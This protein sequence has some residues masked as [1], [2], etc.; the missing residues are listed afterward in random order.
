MV[1]GGGEPN[2]LFSQGLAAKIQRRESD[3]TVSE[4]APRN[5]L[6]YITMLLATEDLSL[7]ENAPIP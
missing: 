2:R 4:T 5:F 6:N 1:A 3:N 7:I